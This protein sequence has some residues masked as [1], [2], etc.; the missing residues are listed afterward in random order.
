M[1]PILRAEVADAAAILSLQK[2]AYRSEAELYNDW[3]IPPLT[4]SLAALLTEFEDHLILKA[5]TGERII[6]SVRA[7]AN[8]G[9]CAVGKLMVHPEF[10]G[11][12][13]GSAL[14]RAIEAG[15]S[16]ATCCQLFTG[17]LSEANIRLYQR[18]GY[19]ITRTQPLLPTVS[20]IYLEKPLNAVSGAP[21]RT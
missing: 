21:E 16:S 14:L 5:V 10:Q 1:F 3:T 12:G 9:V 2:I 19:K 8:D 11:R 4:Q 6:G 13:V 15:F 18:H 17:S 7:K 20:I